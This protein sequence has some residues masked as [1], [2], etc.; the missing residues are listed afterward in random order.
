MIEACTIISGN[1]LS[2]ARVLAESFLEHNPGGR[3]VTLVIDDVTRTTASRV[4]GQ[5][6]DD[7]R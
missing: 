4:S 3:F 1:Y 7:A 6:R 5:S 2:H